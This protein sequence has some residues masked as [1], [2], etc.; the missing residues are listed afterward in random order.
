M[1]ISAGIAAIAFVI[2]VFAFAN[3]K[4]RQPYEPG[5]AIQIPYLGIQFLAVVA[6]VVLVA[7][8]FSL[9]GK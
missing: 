6:I 3:Y 4:A 8:L 2:A 9:G 1:S 7:Y 5:K